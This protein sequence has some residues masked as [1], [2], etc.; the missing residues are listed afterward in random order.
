VYGDLGYG[1]GGY[2]IEYTTVGVERYFYPTN[3]APGD[4]RHMDFIAGLLA[5]TG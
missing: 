2:H 3:F 5:V 1:G 4:Q